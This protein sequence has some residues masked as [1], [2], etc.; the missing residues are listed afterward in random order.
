MT[1]PRLIL[2]SGSPRRLDI[3]RQL[4]LEPVVRVADVDETWL[5]HEQPGDH[6]RRLAREKA[7][8][9]RDL[10]PEGLVLAGDTVVV[11]DGV[12]LGKPRSEA[13][14]VD[15]L[16][17]LAG[18]SHEVLTALALSSPA[19]T[20]DDL[21]RTTVRFRA[22]DE[23]VAR[24]YV[25]TGEPMDKAGAYGIQGLGAAL[26]EEVDG[27]YYS[28]VGLPVSGLLRLL[29]RAGWRYDFGLLESVAPPA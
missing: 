18:R 26:V 21:T 23:G 14:A 7:R 16:V 9:V 22:F 1:G 15:M 4:K 20:W 17:S 2:A 5:P 8:T 12:V 24:R 19:G 13:E 10:E 11:R 6:V 27:D 28:I 3:L 25:A 29:V